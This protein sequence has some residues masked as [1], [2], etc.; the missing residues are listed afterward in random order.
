MFE[1]VNGSCTYTGVLRYKRT[2]NRKSR[3]LMRSFAT[4]LG[5]AAF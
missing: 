4:C 3:I 1:S 5:Q 2:L